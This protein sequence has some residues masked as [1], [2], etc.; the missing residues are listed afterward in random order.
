[1]SLR[2]G[3]AAGHP[4]TTEAG[5]EVLEAGGSAADAAVAASLA[6]CVAETMM[7]GLAG[8]GHAI[9][10]DGSSDEVCLLDFFVTV[11]GLEGSRVVAPLEDVGIPFENEI[12][13]YQVGI[14]SCAVP[15]VPA[16]LDELWRR[17][18]RL[19]W[20]RVVEPAL[21]LARN[22]VEVPPAH[23]ACLAML[24]PVMTLPEGARI[25]APHGDL[26][27]AG[28]RLAQPAS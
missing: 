13:H 15:G 21:E 27:Q 12:V 8:G 23:A 5:F 11:P 4:A 26:L 1:V 17:Y 24:A 7:T 14:A 10:L 28:E 2:P 6:S 20:E 19:P 25:Y 22:G 9:W 16:G 3:I 18:G